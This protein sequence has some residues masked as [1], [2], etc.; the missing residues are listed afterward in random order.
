[1]NED[2][3]SDGLHGYDVLDLAIHRSWDEESHHLVFSLELHLEREALLCFLTA[4]QARH[5]VDRLNQLF[6][7]VP[8]PSLENP[9]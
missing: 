7:P 9:S 8:D 3:G 4:D 5:I 2:A 6:L 1:M